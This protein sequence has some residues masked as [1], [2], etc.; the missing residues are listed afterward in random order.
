[1]TKLKIAAV[2]TIILGLISLAWIFYDYFAL[3]NIAYSFNETL[4]PMRKEEL[5]SMSKIVTL[6]FIPIILFHFAFFITMYLLFEFLK[7]QK[8][9]IKENARLKAEQLKAEK[10]NLRQQKN[11][12][13]QRDKDKNIH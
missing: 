1:M 4:T 3:T 5:N 13:A 8:P 6:G 2:I 11:E 9:F 10:L 12:A 7:I